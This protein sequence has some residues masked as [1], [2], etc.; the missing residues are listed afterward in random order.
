MPQAPLD[1][2]P[3]IA[4]DVYLP[5]TAFDRNGELLGTGTAL[6]DENGLGRFRLE[7]PRANLFEVEKAHRVHFHS[8]TVIA[9]HWYR[10]EAGGGDDFH[11]LAE[12]IAE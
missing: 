3:E 2:L 7:I 10:C 8:G 4:R 12:E 11:F 5:A 9:T 6:L 1:F